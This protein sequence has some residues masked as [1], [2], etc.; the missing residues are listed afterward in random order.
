MLIMNFHL[1]VLLSLFA[2]SLLMAAATPEST[3][4][5]LSEE[6]F[7]LALQKILPLSPDQIQ[8]IYKAYDKKQEITSFA[9]QS[10]PNAVTGSRTISLSP[11]SE[12]P[13][14][15]LGKGYIS[16]V[17]FLDKTG[18]P[19]PIANYS[20]GNPES[21][22]INWDT[23]SNTLFVQSMKT[24]GVANIGIRLKGLATP[25]MLNFISSQGEIDYRL[26][27]TVPEVGP[28]AREDLL[29]FDQGYK[30]DNR[31]LAYLDGAPPMTGVPLVI[32][33]AIGEAWLDNGKVVLRLKDTLISP[34]WSAQTMSSDGTKVYEINRV[35][36]VVISR[37]GSP[38]T[39][40]IKGL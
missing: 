5:K 14:V 3:T 31:L 2:T 9:N 15:R 34:Q 16:S 40:T 36:T 27:F 23:E 4:N 22:D 12:I 26:D 1:R 35:N 33:P 21:F 37:K 18:Q 24:W 25:I 13:I 28:N 32:D 30:V 39:V 10:V 20:L 29:P 38:K 19:W 7:D 8:Q 11:G 6:A 17:L